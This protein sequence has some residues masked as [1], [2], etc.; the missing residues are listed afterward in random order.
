MLELFIQ[1][2]QGGRFRYKTIEFIRHNATVIAKKFNGDI[3]TMFDAFN[4]NERNIL[5]FFRKDIKGIKIKA[6]W[7]LREMRI[8]GVWNVGGQYCCVP[9]KQVGN[10]L[11]RWNYI[12]HYNGN[13]NTH[14]QCSQI[15]WDYFGELYDFPVLHYARSFQCNSR[16]RMCNSCDIF[17]CKDRQ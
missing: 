11:R 17:V 9:D 6:F 10:A 16:N 5:Q 2:Y 3:R 8:S 12:H 1:Y 14:L 13:L 7:L 4:G 15:L